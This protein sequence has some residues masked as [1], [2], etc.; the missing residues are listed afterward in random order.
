MYVYMSTEVQQYYTENQVDVIRVYAATHNFKVKTFCLNNN[1]MVPS[2][3]AKAGVS[4]DIYPLFGYFAEQLE[5]DS[6]Q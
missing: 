4:E 6:D 1:N 5:K 3:K 2:I